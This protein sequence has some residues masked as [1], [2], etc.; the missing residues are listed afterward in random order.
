MAEAN[1]FSLSGL[2]QLSTGI[3]WYSF[4]GLIA[5]TTNAKPVILVNNTGQRDAMITLTFNGS[6]ALADLNAGSNSVVH[7]ILGGE[8]VVQ[9]KIQTL[10]AG[11][12]YMFE[13]SLFIPRNSTL[14]VD[15]TDA[16]TTGK[17]TTMI[18]AY[19]V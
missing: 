7:I 3:G 12:P 2:N 4:S 11:N 5:C 17:T 13:C 6:V 8:I 9:N 16:D 14:R 19:Y 18:R 15:V 1:T 10:D